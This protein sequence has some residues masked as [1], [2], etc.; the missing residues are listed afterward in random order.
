MKMHP[1][2]PNLP[3]WWSALLGFFSLLS[4][5]DY[6]FIVGALISAFFTIKTYYAKRKEERERLA[7]ERRRT[8]IMEDYLHGVS[9]K[10]ESER[11]AAIEV[12]AEA[13]RRAEG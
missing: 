2:N 11:P 1:D 12:V 7:E 9:T 10:P 8:K 13:M 4:L 5:Q 3:Y 6:V